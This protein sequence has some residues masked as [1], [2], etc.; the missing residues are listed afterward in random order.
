MKRA[1]FINRKNAQIREKGR[2]CQNKQ[3]HSRRRS[4]YKLGKKRR[5]LHHKGHAPKPQKAHA[6]AQKQMRWHNA[7]NAHNPKSLHAYIKSHMHIHKEIHEHIQRSTCTYIRSTC[8]YTKGTHAL[9][10]R[11]TCVRP[12]SG[13][14]CFEK[15]ANTPRE[16][17]LLNMEVHAHTPRSTRTFVRL[18]KWFSA[19]FDAMRIAVQVRYDA[20]ATREAVPPRAFE[21]YLFW[22]LWTTEVTPKEKP[23]TRKTNEGMLTS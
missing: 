3:A 12:R 19:P 21:R 10:Q 2:V 4:V 17:M 6:Y 9:M 20:R 23:P 8:T 15:H 16:Q 11:S 1:S 22:W 7:G 14:V 13:N 5:H 18:W